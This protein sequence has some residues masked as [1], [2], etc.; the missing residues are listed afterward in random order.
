MTKNIKKIYFNGNN[1]IEIKGEK[2]KYAALFNAGTL[3]EYKKDGNLKAFNAIIYK[4]NK[5]YIIVDT[6]DKISFRFVMKLIRK[7]DLYNIIDNFM[8][9]SISNVKEINQFKCH[10]YFKNNLNLESNKIKINASNLDILVN[11]LVFESCSYSRILNSENLPELSQQMYKELLN[12]NSSS[13]E[14]KEEIQE[15]IKEPIKINADNKINDILKCLCID[16]FKNYD[17][18]WVIGAILKEINN[19]NFDIFNEYSKNSGYKK[20]NYNDVLNFWNNH[21]VNNSNNKKSIYSL[22][23]L[24][25][26]D[27]PTKYK[28]FINKYYKCNNDF[29]ESILNTVY[30]DAFIKLKDLINIDCNISK[31]IINKSICHY[32]L[33]ELG[34]PR[35]ET[36]D[37]AIIFNIC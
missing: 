19:N 14:I 25:K 31:N 33:F 24:A 12:F 16:R 10:F 5:E 6:D 20:Y 35:L 15:P 4:N 9:L 22:Y 28:E 7:Y 34:T 23:S 30:S 2:Q 11:S 8:T 1:E 36:V 26:E 37:Y 17:N 21:K 18:W 13:N 29:L 3:N 27:N 32:L